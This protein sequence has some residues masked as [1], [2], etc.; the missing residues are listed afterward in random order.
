MLTE[1]LI[2][3]ADRRRLVI[4]EAKTTGWKKIKI[5]SKYQ[6]REDKNIAVVDIFFQ[7]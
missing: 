7:V 2:F 1:R 3:L 5:N 6:Q 4:I